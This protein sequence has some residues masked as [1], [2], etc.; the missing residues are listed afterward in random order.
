[1][2]DKT[3]GFWHCFVKVLANIQQSQSVIQFCVFRNSL[4]FMELG[5]MVEEAAIRKA[6]ELVQVDIEIYCKLAKYSISRFGKVQINVRAE[7]F[8]YCIGS[9]HWNLSWKFAES[10]RRYQMCCSLKTA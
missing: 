6:L 4:S 5:E 9:I 1:M 8:S 10:S 7:L 3:A 2:I